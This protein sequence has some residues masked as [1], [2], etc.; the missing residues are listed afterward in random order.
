MLF[1]LGAIALNPRGEYV[2][3]ETYNPL[4]LVTLNG[5]SYICKVTVAGVA[6]D[7]PNSGSY[8]WQENAGRGVQGVQGPTGAGAQGA[9]G[10]TG[11]QGPVGP[12]GTGSIGPQGATGSTG[13]RGNA[14]WYCSRQLTDGATVSITDVKGSFDKLSKGDMIM[15]GKGQVFTIVETDGSTGRI[16]LDNRIVGGVG[17]TGPQGATGSRGTQGY[18]GPQG[19]DGIQGAQGTVTT[20]TGT[21]AEYEALQEIDP[22]VFYIITDQTAGTQGV[23]GP[24]GAT[25]PIADTIPFWKILEYKPLGDGSEGQVILIDGLNGGDFYYIEGTTSAIVL[26]N[27]VVGKGGTVS[28]DGVQTLPAYVRLTA[29]VDITLAPEMFEN[30]FVFASNGGKLEAGKTYILTFWQYMIL[31]Q[32]LVSL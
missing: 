5:T 3:G 2:P 31:V 13:E 30:V 9:Q 20:W 25:G 10:T 32:E 7:N 26:E 27:I 19:A 23:Q 1:D 21:L 4:D 15:D 11:T 8:Y 16:S 18:D 22:T 14:W 24:M 17:A 28:N 6:P 29:E 12:G